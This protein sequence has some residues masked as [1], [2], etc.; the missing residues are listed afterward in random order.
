MTQQELIEKLQRLEAQMQDLR[1]EV[2]RGHTP[3]RRNV[4]GLVVMLLAGFGLGS[5]VVSQPAAIGQDEGRLRS[6]SLRELKIQDEKGATRLHL[7]LDSGLPFIR[8]Q[9]PEGKTLAFLQGAARGGLLQ[10]N[11]RDGSNRVFLDVSEEGMGGLGFYN[12]RNAQELFLG[13]SLNKWGGMIFVNGSDGK[14][15]AQLDVAD[16][17][18]GLLGF[19]NADGKQE[20]IIGSSANGWGGIFNL[21]ARDGG[22]PRII[23]DINEKG[24]GALGIFNERFKRE[25]YVGASA[26]GWGGLI[27]LNAPDGTSKAIFDV[28]NNE[29]GRISLYNQGGRHIWGAPR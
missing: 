12:D 5:L 10:L 4:L 28:D 23:L 27:N 24:Q 6:L 16:K 18:N 26:K 22:D 2:A 14:K 1:T 3:R 19:Y 9:N 8:V 21:R 25:V 7:G 29:E 20:A 15:R 13:S 11:A 17:G